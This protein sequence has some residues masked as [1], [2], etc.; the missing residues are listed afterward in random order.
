[1]HRG[2]LLRLR[3]Y[4]LALRVIIGLFS[5]CLFVLCYSFAAMLVLETVFVT[6]ME[7]VYE[8]SWEPF[9]V[10]LNSPSERGDAAT[11]EPFA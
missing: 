9:S 5:F 2:I 3:G 4:L 6:A 7:I 11:K 1:M 8:T 10:K